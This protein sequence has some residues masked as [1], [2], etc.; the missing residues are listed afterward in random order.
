[1]KSKLLLIFVHGFMGSKDSFLTFPDDISQ[2]FNADYLC[3]EYETKGEYDVKTKNLAQFL[4]NISNSHI[5]ILSHSMGG[6]LS[7]DA[8]KLRPNPR[9]KG[10]LTFDSPF[11]GLDPWITKA[12]ANRAQDAINSVSS[13]LPKSSSWGML[14][15][16]VG[17]A[18][19]L[20]A[21][22]RPAVKDAVF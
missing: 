4:N 20:F 21:A 6:P 14:A 17:A 9:V 15:V 22:A 2:Q 13:Y 1:M 18:A 12:G 10:V 11:F 16:G 8:L 3:Y 5:V 7:I 19:A